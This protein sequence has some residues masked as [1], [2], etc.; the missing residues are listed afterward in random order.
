MEG[1]PL[2]RTARAGYPAKRVSGKLSSLSMGPDGTFLF[3]RSVERQNNPT[4]AAARLCLSAYGV[5]LQC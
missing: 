3:V 1:E 4:E 2:Q 5:L